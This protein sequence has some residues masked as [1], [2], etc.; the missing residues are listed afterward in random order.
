[1]QIQLQWK[2]P[3]VQTVLIP[4]H[5]LWCDIIHHLTIK[6]PSQGTIK[7]PSEGTIKAPYF[8]FL[9]ICVFVFMYLNVRH[10]VFEILVAVV[11]RAFQKYNTYTWSSVKPILSGEDTQMGGPYA[12]S[13]Y[14]PLSYFR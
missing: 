13:E 6:A 5:I 4:G 14:W 8:K 11:Q 9:P 3:L 2:L 10:I 12:Y 1:M 7:A